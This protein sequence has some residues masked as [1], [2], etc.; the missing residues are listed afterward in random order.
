MD[1]D[2]T[3]V[4]LERSK[5][6][7]INLRINR[8]TDLST[9]DPLLQVIPLAAGRLKSLHLTGSPESLFNLTAHL[10]HPAPLLE[11]LLIDGDCEYD[12]ETNPVFATSLFNGDLSPLRSLHLQS[13]RTELPWRNMVNLTSFSLWY[14]SPGEVTIRHLL[15]FF[16]GAP[17][18]R[19]IELPT[20]TPGSNVQDGRLVP[21]AYLKRAEFFEGES[22][23]ILLNHL[24]IP[25]GARLTTWVGLPGPLIQDHLP[26][27]LDN[28]RNLSDFTK[29]HLRVLSWR[30]LLRFSGPNGQ[31]R[32]FSLRPRPN[33]TSLVLKSLARFGTSKTKRLKIDHGDTS[34]VDSPYQ[35]LLP[36]SNLRT[37]TLFQ[38]LNPHHF[39]DA[40]HP[41]VSRTVVCPKLEKLVL[42]LRVYGETLDVERLTGMAA[43]RALRGL[44]LMAVRILTREVAF[45]VLELEKHVLHVECG[46]EVAVVDGDSD[47]GDGED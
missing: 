46:P 28:L 25:V 3:R 2:K 31:V 32:M 10:A 19:E 26:R 33:N 22:T 7:P 41:G 5:S 27:S 1:A 12:P 45:D 37:L 9:H 6:S 29:I 40:L 42:V 36:M 8:K 44:K 11:D 18:L 38:C 15:D 20:P 43:A 23:S 13:V 17:R 30:S 21:L 16:E 34:S 47:D 39:I 14:M 4:Y 24:L 35:T